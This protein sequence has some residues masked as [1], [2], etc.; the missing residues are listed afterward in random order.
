[1]ISAAAAS[2]L[3]GCGGGKSQNSAASSNTSSGGAAAAQGGGAAG[4]QQ[5]NASGAV[6]GS[7][8]G[9]LPAYPG[10]QPGQ[11]TDVSSAAGGTAGR[12]VT[13]TTADAPAQVIEFYANAASQGGLQTI[14][15]TNVGPNSTIAFLKGTEA[16]QVIASP[17]GGR[18]QIQIAGA[19][20][21]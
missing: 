10:A 13:F 11:A 5:A 4:A 20:T 7:L 16:I 9:G 2:L 3:A 12:V 21:R 19:S 15:R 1:M 8:P 14:A 18:T 17:L 6:A